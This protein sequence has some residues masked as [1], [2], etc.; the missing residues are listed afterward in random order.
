MAREIY[1]VAGEKRACLELYILGDAERMRSSWRVPSN[2]V[3]R[4]SIAHGLFAVLGPLLGR[5]HPSV[6]RLQ[7][8]SNNSQFSHPMT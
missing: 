5:Q 6:E 1:P 7:K 2:W 3:Y 4:S 8:I